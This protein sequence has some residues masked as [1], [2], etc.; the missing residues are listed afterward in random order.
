MGRG[1]L[2]EETVLPRL[3]PF[4]SCGTCLHTQRFKELPSFR[5]SSTPMFIA[6]T[7]AECLLCAVIISSIWY[8][9]NQ[10]VGQ[11]CVLSSRLPFEVRDVLSKEVEAWGNLGK[12]SNLH[13]ITWLRS[14]NVRI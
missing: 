12:G 14:S 5:P 2:I 9:A 11:G 10:G 4:G 13:K 8:Y 6:Q 3:N 7:F 1:R